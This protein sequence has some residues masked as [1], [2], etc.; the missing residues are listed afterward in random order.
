[1]RRRRM[2]ATSRQRRS[3]QRGQDYK[4]EA[5]IHSR[6]VYPRLAAARAQNI[7]KLG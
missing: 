2:Q 4:R 1:L 5:G 7:W 6:G 3:N